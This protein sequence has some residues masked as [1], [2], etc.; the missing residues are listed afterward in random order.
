MSF[1]IRIT[2]EAIADL[3]RLDRSIAQ[4]LVNKARWTAEHFEDL[5]HQELKGD[6][7]GLY[8]L[9]VGNVRVIYSVDHERRELVV[10]GA[11]LRSDIY[12]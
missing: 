10:R 7:A 3:R 2:D 5:R 6:L 9:R 11:G 12:D 8:K 4:R 1:S